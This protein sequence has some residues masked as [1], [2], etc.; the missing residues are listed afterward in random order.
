MGTSDRK[1]H[2]W[3]FGIAAV[4]TERI[5]QLSTLPGLSE[6]PSVVGLLK[7][8]EQQVLIAT[9]TVHCWQYQTDRDSMIP[10]HKMICE[11]ESQGVVNKNYSPFNSL[12]CPVCKSDGEWRLTVDYRGLNE[13]TLSL[14]TTMLDMLELQYE[15]ESKAAKWCHH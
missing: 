15:L 3:A 12:I 4:E 5:K 13:V 6:N 8:E 2:P 1:G 7:V 11:L 9:S 10:I 14:S